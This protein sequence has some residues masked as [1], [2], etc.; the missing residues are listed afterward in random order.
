MKT[1]IFTFLLIFLPVGLMA[2][3]S[4]SYL[5]NSLRNCDSNT[6]EEILFPDPGPSGPNQ[7]WDF[8]HIQFTGTNQGS[9]LMASTTPKLPGVG[10][11]NLL[12]AENGYEFLM[13]SNENELEELGYVNYEK[14]LTLLYSDPVVKMKYPFSFGNQ[15]TDHFVGVALYDGT[16]KIDFFGDFTV[17][18]DAYGTLILPDRVV[19]NALRV[20][21]VK[22][23]LQINTCGTTD[24]SIVKY[25]WYAT[26]YRYPLL[27]LNI[28]ETMGN[29]CPAQITKTAFTNMQQPGLK[30]GVL[31]A[32]A[33]VSISPEGKSD[34]EVLVSPNPFVDQLTYNYILTTPLNVSIEVYDTSGKTHG[35]LVKNQMQ[36]EGLHNGELSAS[37]FG[38]T[39]GLYFM[40]FTFDN[41]VIIHKIVKL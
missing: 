14:K 10:N 31:V 40:R 22:K 37:N 12:L 2:Q 34:V 15:F 17:S 3:T 38:L 11:C 29:G 9:V 32:N 23:G 5:N 21:S 20:K 19:N 7:T 39:P 6:S 18:A 24:I 30:S 13:N 27:S 25:S 16:S 28:V 41:Q 1:R 35:W 36:T 8:S 4:L 33:P 26:G